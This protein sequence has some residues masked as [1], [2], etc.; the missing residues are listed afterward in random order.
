MFKQ[1]FSMTFYRKKQALIVILVIALVMFLLLSIS[2][3]FS[4]VQDST[5]LAAMEEYGAFH[6]IYYALEEQH[7]AQLREIASIKEMGILEN[8]G[9]Y[10]LCD[11]AANITLGR[12]DETALSLSKLKL[13]E[14]HWPQQEGEIAVEKHVLYQMPAGAGL[15]STLRVQTPRGEAVYTI[16]GVVK[17]YRG[18]WSVPDYIQE[19]VNDL[20]TGFIYNGQGLDESPVKSAMLYFHTL[21]MQ[22][23]PFSLEAYVYHQQLGLGNNGVDVFNFKSNENLYSHVQGGRLRMSLWYEKYFVL[24]TLA[25]AGLILYGVLFGYYR[26]FR[27]MSYALYTMGAPKHTMGGLLLLNSLILC[28]PAAGLGLG[29]AAILSVV[30]QNS[31]GSRLPLLQKAWQVGIG[32]LAVVLVAGVYYLWKLRPLYGRNYSARGEEKRRWRKK[33]KEAEQIGRHLQIALAAHHVQRNWKRLVAPLLVAAVLLTMVFCIQWEMR[34]TTAGWIRE[35]PTLSSMAAKGWAEAD[36]GPYVLSALHQFFDGQRID[37]IASLP[38]VWEVYKGYNS[39]ACLVVPRGQGDYWEIFLQNNPGGGFSFHDPSEIAAIPQEQRA[40]G[41]GFGFEVLNEQEQQWLQRAYPE[42]EVQKL[43]ADGQAIL[44]CPPIDELYFETGNEIHFGEEH[45]SSIPGGVVYNDAIKAGD[46]L[47]LAWLESDLPLNEAVLKPDQIRYCEA[48]LPLSAVIN[49]PFYMERAYSTV[50]GAYGLTILLSEET[51]RQV[52]Y[53]N[54]VFN[55]NVYMHEDI[56][57]AEYAAVEEAFGRIAYSISGTNN[58][59][60]RE[61]EAFWQKMQYAHKMTFGILCVVLGGFILTSLVSTL[62]G[63]LLQR[64]RMFGILRANGLRRRQL[65]GMILAELLVYWMGMGVLC[66]IIG[67]RGSYLFSVKVIGVYMEAVDLWSLAGNIGVILL[68]ALAVFAGI[69]WL[70]TRRVWKQSVS[71]V[72][73]FAE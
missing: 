24:L 9:N 73:R 69:A 1:A 66:Y 62:Y 58:Y 40:T 49:E 36:Y 35:I 43:L 11:A 70:L 64:R 17:D 65:F 25:G 41:L 50:E 26:N 51:A 19:G 60:S 22:D 33:E 56:S 13:L 63:T 52:E 29:G 7:F 23:D 71:E 8:Y 3:V 31:I 6:C 21:K 68:G 10:P 27:E 47:L 16:C 28:L 32:V 54:G 53:I 42:L 34:Q 67:L 37:Q 59:S 30:M 20:P 44:F 15:G 18:K 55:F 4:A 38:G 61:E 12:F 72:I 14:G 48:Q 5:F 45:Y 2:S 57:E 39:N 46:A